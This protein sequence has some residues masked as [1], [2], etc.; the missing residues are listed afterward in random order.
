[1]L[2]RHD[3]DGRHALRRVWRK[4]SQSAF[5]SLALAMFV[6]VATGVGWNLLTDWYGINTAFAALGALYAIVAVFYISPLGAWLI[7]AIYRS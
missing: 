6:V 5:G 7:R 1:M 4:L 3:F 2:T